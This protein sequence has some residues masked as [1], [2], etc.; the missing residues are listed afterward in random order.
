M[1]F[2]G[3]DWKEVERLV[4]Q[5]SEKQ[6]TVLSWILAAS[7]AVLGNLAV[8]L[9]FAV[10]IFAG[11]LFWMFL[12]LLIVVVLILLYLEFLPKVTA[13]LRF[14][15]SYVSFPTGYEQYITK[16][17]CTSPYSRIIFSYGTLGRKV[18]N[19]GVLV[20]TAILKDQLCSWS[21]EASYVRV[22]NIIEIGE[23]IAYYVEIST[24]GAKP[25]LDPQGREKIKIEL[26]NLITA[27]FNA[28]QIC[29]VHRFELDPKEWDIH[30]CDFVDGV[31]EWKLDEVRRAI[32]DKLQSG[33]IR[34]S[35][36]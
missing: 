20:R 17:P 32:V 18:T 25:W 26:R 10:P 27:M 12:C 35:A 31:S 14:I 11:N 2:Q 19:F 7:I 16:A 9:A 29:S 33:G 8:N 15:P 28:R 13:V 36:S 3:E 22:S 6:K 4:E 1:K 30:G 5:F 24:N 23:G 21:K 34:E